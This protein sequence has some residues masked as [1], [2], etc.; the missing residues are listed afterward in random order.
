[1]NA[2]DRDRD[3]VTVAVELP[4]PV[5]DCDVLDERVALADAALDLEMHGDGD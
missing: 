3:V 5:V 1:M 4:V 2:F